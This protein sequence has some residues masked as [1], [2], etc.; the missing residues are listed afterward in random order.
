LARIEDLD[1]VRKVVDFLVIATRE[2]LNSSNR[3]ESR[4]SEATVE[5]DTLRQE[6]VQLKA[7]ALT[8]ALTGLVNRWGLES[9][10]IREIRESINTGRPLCVVLADIDHFKKINDTYGHLVGD[11][12]IKMFAATLID[13]VKGRDLVA[14]FGGE[15]FLIVLPDTPLIGAVTLSKKMQVFLENMKWKRKETGTTLGKI[16]LSFGV[17][18]YRSNEQ[19]EDLIRRADSAL[20]YSKEHGR[21]RVTSET[22]L[23]S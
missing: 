16:T 2:I 11:N 1:A 5:V 8:D 22:E 4:L 14:R 23:P 3:L 15:E 21:N 6:M 10:L 18:Q 19:I 7:K 20:Y 9:L 12:V 17:A 13:F